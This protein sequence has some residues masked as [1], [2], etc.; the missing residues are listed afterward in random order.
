MCVKM[1]VLTNCILGVL[2]IQHVYGAGGKNEKIIVDPV[3]NE[4]V[5]D[6]SEIL[7]FPNDQ[8]SGGQK[9]APSQYPAPSDTQ[10]QYVAKDPT[11]EGGFQKYDKVQCPSKHTGL[12][13]YQ[14]DC[15]KF[16]NCFKGRG[17]IQVCASGTLFNSESLECD[18]PAKAVCASNEPEPADP[19]AINEVDG[20]VS[21]HKPY[22]HLDTEEFHHHNMK[23]AIQTV[24]QSRNNPHNYINNGGPQNVGMTE[25][26]L[27]D[28]NQA[29]TKSTAR[30]ADRAFTIDDDG[31]V[32]FNGNDD[33]KTNEKRQSNQ[34]TEKVRCPPG[35]DG[36]LPHPNSCRK[37]LSCANGQTFESDCAPGT[38]FNPDLSIC[39]FPYNVDCDKDVLP[40]PSR[41][42]RSRD[43]DTLTDS[44][45]Q[46]N[47]QYSPDSLDNRIGFG[48]EPH[49]PYGSQNQQT[50]Y[51][52][53]MAHSFASNRSSAVQKENDF[54]S[55]WLTHEEQ[56]PSIM[57]SGVGVSVMGR[58]LWIWE[59]SEGAFVHQ[60][61]WPG[62]DSK[63][64]MS[65]TPPSMRALCVLLKRFYDCPSKN[66]KVDP[67]TKQGATKQ[68]KGIKCDSE[69]FF[70]DT[71]DCG[72]LTHT[73]PYICKRFSIQID[74]MTRLFILSSTTFIVPGKKPNSG[75]MVR[76]RG[77]S[78]PSE[79]FLELKSSV[80]TDWG[81]VCD[82]PN[83]W[84]MEE[85]NVI[86]RQL[87][88]GGGAD[89]TWQGRPSSSHNTTLKKPVVI[90]EVEC[91]GRESSIM[92]CNITKGRACDVDK[93]SIWIRCLGNHASQCRPGEVSYSNKCYSL[94][95]P[96]E[97]APVNNETVGYSQSEAIKHCQTKG[98]HLLDITSQKEN[99]F[100]SE[101][102]THEEQLPSI[103]TSGVGVS[104][105]GRPL[106]FW[107][108]SETFVHQN[109]WP[110]NTLW[111]TKS[112]YTL[113]FTKSANTLWFTESTYT[114]WFTKSTNTIW[115]TKSTYT[116]WFTKS[117]N[118][119][120][121]SKSA[122]TLWFTKSTYTLWFTKSAN[123]LWFTKSTYTLWFTKSTNTICFTKSTYTLW[124]T[125][126][127]YTLWF[128][129]SANTL[130]FTK[131]TYTLWFTKSTNTIW[132]TKSTNSLWI[133]KSTN[134]LWFT[135]STNPLWFTKSTNPLWFTKSANTLWITKSANTLWFTK[136][137]YTLWFTKKNGCIKDK[138]KDYKGNANV[139]RLGF[140]CL[141]WDNPS[142]LSA[143][144]YE[145]SE[146]ARKALLTGHDHCRNPGGREDMPWCYIL[147]NVGIVKDYCDIPS[148]RTKDTAKT[149]ESR[150][151]DDESCGANLFQC[152]ASDCIP[153]NW[154]C[155]G[156]AVSIF[157]LKLAVLNLSPNPLWFTKSANTLWITKSTNTLCQQ[158]S[159]PTE[160]SIHD[161]PPSNY[162][163]PTSS[164]YIPKHG[165]PQQPNVQQGNPHD[166]KQP[167]EGYDRSQSKPFAPKDNKF[168]PQIEQTTSPDHYDLLPDQN[169]TDYVYLQPT[170]DFDTQDLPQGR[171]YPVYSLNSKR[172]LK[173]KVPTANGIPTFI[174]PGKKPNSGQMVRL[175]GGSRPSEGFLELKSSVGTDWGL[176]CDKPNGWSMEEANV[177]CRQLGYGGGADFTWQGRPSSSHNTTLKKP[178]VIKEV[179]CS[180]RE[181]SIMDCN[182]TKGKTYIG[183]GYQLYIWGADLTWQGRP[184]SSHNTTLKK[185]VVIK[186][187][188]C[189]GRES[190]IMDCNITKGRACDVDKD[191]IW[192]R[193]LGNHA[194]QCRPGEVSY[195]NKC[196]SLVIPSEETPVNNETV[197]YSQSEAIKHCQTKG[198]HLIKDQTCFL[199][200]QNIGTSGAL[201]VNQPNWDYYELN[202]KSINC[203][204]KFVCQNGKCIE[205]SDMCNG[206]NNCGDRSDEMSCPHLE[207]G[208]KIRLTSGTNMTHLG[209]VEIRVFGEWGVV[210][211]DKFGMK[212]ADVICRELGFKMGAA[213]TYT[214]TQS[215]TVNGSHP[216]PILMDDVECIGNETSLKD[217]PFN[218]WGIHD[219]SP[220]EVAGV[221]C[222]IPGL[223]CKTNFWMCQNGEECIPNAFLCD[224]T[225]DCLDGTDEEPKVCAK[226]RSTT[227]APP[228][229]SVQRIP[230]KG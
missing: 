68:E 125:K 200:D 4:R 163:H 84:S 1:F 195:S 6:P 189:S 97:E 230:K 17:F 177:I 221:T 160:L 30:N 56:V 63:V 87:G 116:L 136:S 39:D 196:Y 23:R 143:L 170:Q 94:V 93:D 173:S 59:G 213:E 172:D 3:T 222:S 100:L 51:G 89:L 225:I 175:R 103:M 220:E 29:G 129:K 223:K 135:K 217:C 81:L 188:E 105:M 164:G 77:G 66:T 149:I 218:G 44:E 111:F 54:L 102:L 117:A 108:G 134:T 184:S 24:S 181:S 15:R 180:G 139:T 191:S 212:D 145:V 113:W 148:C 72:S 211:D 58:P 41:D 124:F 64:A 12:L 126:S 216:L 127:T 161:K 219:C 120:W 174:V 206:F 187:V 9:F 109:W 34:K 159:T 35:H 131:S 47:A 7:R 79:G 227:P 215:S 83:G 110:A 98:G 112:T 199:S 90:K 157:S 16:I 140:N 45:S 155:D 121:I 31:K 52:L 142:V 53:C 25:A 182:I 210:C 50:P 166:F 82:K 107:E 86:C 123:T 138:G 228:K 150:A 10:P 101:W 205:K 169:E 70:W 190:S 46:N 73:H 5:H 69:Y 115:F 85:A 186:K 119:L 106:W 67:N 130:W 201:S 33:E 198:G 168:N 57:T 147:T 43:T 226:I 28:L 224:G 153:K 19:Y 137:T 165:S 22:T 14:S 11:L 118:T 91:S 104:V 92:D 21:L 202:A 197:G 49:A 75:Q 151:L 80:G 8:Y 185:P 179:E 167:S 208:Y 61:W 74:L 192:I 204:G 27:H 48:H 60:N 13:P 209:R 229:Q 37:Y 26:I 146:N 78:R 71:A 132:I 55:E 128:T 144:E 40:P 42:F 214:Y 183:I 156:Q 158:G 95:I 203:A 20:E 162:Y 152:E 154:V 141:S 32:L 171:S 2:L 193:C 122:N 178:V 96:S 194:S 176:V 99:D 65:P 62:W 88:Y 133:T 76:L 38:L 114:L 207:L 36:I 18:F